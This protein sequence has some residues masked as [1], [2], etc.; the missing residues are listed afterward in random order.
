LESKRIGHGGDRL[1]SQM[2]GL[3]EKTIRRGRH[4]LDAGLS[5]TPSKRMRQVGRGRLPV[6]KKT[7]R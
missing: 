4:E 3:D 5:D 6:E 2:T 1:L 7:R